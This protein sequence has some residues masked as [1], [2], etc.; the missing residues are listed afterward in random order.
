MTR[1]G[2]IDV[3]LIVGVVETQKCPNGC[4]N[5]AA[6]V[7]HGRCGVVDFWGRVVEKNNT[8]NFATSVPLLDHTGIALWRL[9]VGAE[10][11]NQKFFRFYKI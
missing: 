10:V 1:H 3:A 7:S 2:S 4:R 5:A 6:H 8:L 9:G 11:L